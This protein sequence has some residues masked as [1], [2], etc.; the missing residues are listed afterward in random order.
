ML[1]FSKALLPKN[2]QNSAPKQ[3]AGTSPQTNLSVTSTS[4]DKSL[5]NVSDKIT[6][7]FSKPVDERTIKVS[8]EPE[9]DFDLMLEPDGQTIQIAP[10]KIWKF[11]TKYKLT[12]DG[13][14]T[15]T[16]GEK[17]PENIIMDFR[18]APYSGT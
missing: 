6:F 13:V 11:E 12:I 9:T 5:V 7:K 16:D 18:T 15:G 8:I 1:T 3:P 4:F 17:I 10:K 14:L 2:T